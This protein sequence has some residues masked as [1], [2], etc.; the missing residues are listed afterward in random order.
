MFYFLLY[1]MGKISK[2]VDTSAEKMEKYD[3]ISDVLL[4]L[5]VY[6]GT[7]RLSV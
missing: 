4:T 5:S 3:E 2:N 1:M 6:S 7:K